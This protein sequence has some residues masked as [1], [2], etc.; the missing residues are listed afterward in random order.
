MSKPLE[1]AWAWLKTHI[2][3]NALSLAVLGFVVAISGA[4]ARTALDELVD[5]KLSPMERKQDRYE[6]DVH[7]FAKDIRELY[8]VTPFVRPSKR[9]ERPAYEDH[10]DGGE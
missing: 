10:W 2:N 6:S 9:L 7:E 4:W 8:R 3:S 1:D 5:R